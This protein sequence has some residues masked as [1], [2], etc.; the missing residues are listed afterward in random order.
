MSEK[1]SRYSFGDAKAKKI[2]NFVWL[3]ALS[4]GA[5]LALFYAILYGDFLT[6]AFAAAWRWLSRHQVVMAL[7]A[8][9]PFFAALLV[10]RASAQK[11]R[12]KRL[13]AARLEQDRVAAEH[14]ARRSRAIQEGRFPPGVPSGDSN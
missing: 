9:T 8:S 6:G 7:A 5:M 11:A 3:N 12:R 13:A 4:I 14:R 10:G 1:E 2:W